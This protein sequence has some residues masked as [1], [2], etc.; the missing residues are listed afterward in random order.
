MDYNIYGKLIQ[1]Y[2]FTTYANRLHKHVLWHLYAFLDFFLWMSILNKTFIEWFA[3]S[4]WEAACSE[5]KCLQR[6]KVGNGLID[7]L[8]FFFQPSLRSLW[9]P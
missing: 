9:L 3:I 7:Y 5:T 8:L 4:F 2:S 6:K 1:K